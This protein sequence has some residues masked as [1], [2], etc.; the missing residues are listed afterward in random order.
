M[1]HLCI[2]L[3]CC[4]MGMPVMADGRVVFSEDFETGDFSNK[5]SGIWG[6]GWSL[7][8]NVV[9]TGDL[10]D[11]WVVTP[12]GN[13]VTPAL[14][15]DDTSNK[16]AYI[17]TGDA[18]VNTYSGKNAGTGTK[19]RQ[20][21]FYQDVQFYADSLYL[22]TFDYKS[23]TNTS[24]YIKVSS[25]LPS[26]LP[27]GD[28]A[29]GSAPQ[30]G[31]NFVGT[32]TAWQSASVVYAPT[33]SEIRRLFFTWNNTSTV[34]PPAAAIDNIR[35][36]AYPKVPLTTNVTAGQL[37]AIPNI[38]EV[39]SLTLNGTLNAADFA[40]MR[41]LMP[42][43]ETLNLSG[44]TA[45][46][47][48]NSISNGTLPGTNS[49]PAGQIPENA[50]FN[51]SAGKT[52]L[53][54]I[55]FPTATVKIGKAAFRGCTGLS[56]ALDL[57]HIS[58]IDAQ[59]FYF[60][61]S[62]A[63]VCGNFTGVTFSPDLTSIGDSAF[64]YAFY[65]A[66][67]NLSIPSS[68]QRIGKW[69]FRYYAYSVSSNLTLTFA[70]P[71]QLKTIDE[72]AFGNSTNLK[73]SLTLPD[74]L[75]TIGAYAF[76]SCSGFNDALTLPATLS[77]IGTY[78]FSSCSNMTGSANLSNV[79][80]IPVSVF[81]GC[82][83]LA[84][85]SFSPTLRYIGT[86]AFYNCSVLT[87]PD[88]AVTI[89]AQMTTIGSP[90][91]GCAKLKYVTL[92][93]GLT[94]IGNYGF[95]KTGIISIDLKNVIKIGNTAFSGC[96]ALTTV[97][98]RNVATIGSSAFTDCIA[99]ESI[100]IPIGVKTIESSTF[101]GCTALKTVTLPTSLTGTGT[102]VF[103]SCTSLTQINCLA[104]APPALQGTN[105]NTPFYGVTQGNVSLV[106]PTSAVAAYQIS[107]VTAT[108]WQSFNISGGGFAVQATFTD[109]ALGTIS[110]LENKL[111]P[112]GAITLTAVPKAGAFIDWTT[113]A[114]V[115]ISTNPTLALT[116][117]SDTIVKANFG[118]VLVH[119]N[120]AGAL[121]QVS[122]IETYTRITL[123]GTI[124]AKDIAYIRDNLSEA[125][126]VFLQGATI[127]EY[128]GEEGTLEG[129][130]TYPANTFPQ[131]AF[132][133]GE[134][135]KGL[136]ALTLPANLTAIGANALRGC[137]T[138][139]NNFTIPSG[140]TSIGSYAFSD[141][142]KLTGTLVLP[143]GITSIA[144]FAFYNCSGF[145]GDLIIPIGVTTV[146]A[147][148]FRHCSGLGTLLLPHKLTTIGSRAFDSCSG[149]TSLTAI[150]PDPIALSITNAVF[151]NFNPCV[152]KVADSAVERYKGATL[153]GLFWGNGNENI[154]GA[155]F[156]V[157]AA[158]N[159]EA[160]GSVS[161]LGNKLYT[162][163]DQVTLTATPK[164]GFEFT[165][166]TSNGVQISTNTTLEL[167]ITQDTIVTA[168]FAKDYSGVVLAGELKNVENIALISNLILT[169]G[170]ILDARD[171][172]FMRDQMPY[173]VDLN[174]S[175]ASISAYEGEGGTVS[176]E[177]T[178][179]ANEIPQNALQNKS[180]LA[181]AV[182]PATVTAIKANAFRGT[183][184]LGTIIIPANVAVIDEYA[185]AGSALSSITFA[186]GSLLT[187]IGNSAFEDCSKLT[188]ITLPAE[189]L[190]IGD[191]AFRRTTALSGVLTIPNKVTSIG[192]YAFGNDN[193]NVSSNGLTEV[194][195]PASLLT[196]KSGA[197]RYSKSLTGITLPE[198]L[199]TLEASAFAGCLNLTDRVD[200]PEGITAIADN[201]FDGAAI[202]E[203]HLPAGVTEIGKWAFH[204][205]TL[206]DIYVANSV[207]IELS[208]EPTINPFYGGI[209]D[210]YIYVPEGSFSAYANAPVWK[211]FFFGNASTE[212]GNTDFRIRGIPS[213]STSGK[214]TDISE[215]RGLPDW[216]VND[217]I[218][219][220]DYE[221]NEYYYY[222]SQSA[223]LKAEAIGSGEFV[224]W[225]KA[226]SEGVLST[227]AVYIF[228]V[229]KADTLVAHFKNLLSITDVTP[230]VVK[231]YPNPVVNGL[232]TIEHPTL[233]AGEKI[234]VYN[235]LGGIAGVYAPTPKKTTLYVADL[236]NGSY[237]IKAGKHLEKII[238]I[239]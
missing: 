33:T 32:G 4:L 23:T 58:A 80:S 230:S 145:T 15:Q 14:H 217:P 93:D 65:K 220:G 144:D 165:N 129:S 209:R 219:G 27:A 13:I 83:K 137:A 22:L 94:E 16:V 204:N 164:A 77:A 31:S 130:Q 34:N 42:L 162:T 67:T 39:V 231:I 95:R 62:G 235:L 114:G 81:T 6:N 176:G 194:V 158:P 54:S 50:F 106:V 152:L 161:G 155:G 122:D 56:G 156:V 53:K 63:T 226:G 173:L 107:N 192:S 151:S 233:N 239:Q 52:M 142:S 43:L 119:S 236:P 124:N 28:I 213:N 69:A 5:E 210:G 92:P 131:N 55:T 120:T 139:S 214:V 190:T 117:N 223:T 153:W 17:T 41:D 118:K 183:G 237:Y 71:S 128:T 175:A 66:T 2:F 59:A 234:T 91:D 29:S 184:K 12:S 46:E 10:S 198:N 24:A 126:E 1:K 143:E 201:V 60:T 134:T 30:I 186:G 159:G 174:I 211:Q 212:I 224:N 191:N 72:Y 103:K 157:S 111:Y 216:R 76:Y 166:W 228:E 202:T 87:F 177:V 38:T 123:T 116:V 19:S 110:G 232:V 44:V 97:N 49:Y 133:D 68:V 148:A 225:T 100:T 35:L 21:H 99:L 101:S 73:G 89:P 149:L 187:A 132:Y 227:D 196:I 197:F 104:L 26:Y 135:S 112:A 206:D 7:K 140:V 45:I 189:L 70:S 74:G 121:D 172:A 78:A 167:T 88:D 150:N 169:S 61:G 84:S 40:F 105:T 146:G 36:V 64:V 160:L 221:E 3:F 9:L 108:P 185:F 205:N 180:T 48:V 168:N 8:Q 37:Y 57:S 222:A 115:Q 86:D 11:Y 193:V 218:F 20:A 208:E 141:C 207:P 171:F 178:Y 125:K 200:I 18:T 147:E 203:L 154:E 138:I 229:T 182:L 113:G 215:L 136:V 109:V 85:V 75:E 102:A 51:G 195:L 181:T 25:S 238:V 90:F 170:S 188:G 98:L 127:V 79:D 199:T 96:S 82:A 163:S 179:A 47:A